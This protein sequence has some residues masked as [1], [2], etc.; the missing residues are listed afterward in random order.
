MT[1]LFCLIGLLTEEIGEHKILMVVDTVL[2]V[3]VVIVV[4]VEDAAEGVVRVP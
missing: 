2:A 3:V 1:V 4:V